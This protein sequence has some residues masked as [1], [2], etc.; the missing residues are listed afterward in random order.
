MKYILRT[1]VSLPLIHRSCSESLCSPGLCTQTKFK[2]L[3]TQ[4]YLPKA[5]SYAHRFI[6][7]SSYFPQEIYPGN[8]PPTR[9]S[10]RYGLHLWE[11][12]LSRFILQMACWAF[13]LSGVQKWNRLDFVTVSNSA[14]SAHFYSLESGSLNNTLAQF[15]NDKL[16]IINNQSFC[17]LNNPSSF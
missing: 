2:C 3:V 10:Q 12:E 9:G 14:K 11:P 1:H 13:S 15:P 6:T 7:S 16:L 8:H 17:L 4:F 5:A